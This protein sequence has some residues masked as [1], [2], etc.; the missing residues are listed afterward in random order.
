MRKN[1]F[2]TAILAIIIVFALCACG[3]DGGNSGDYVNNDEIVDENSNGYDYENNG[4]DNENAERVLEG[5]VV[6]ILDDE[7]LFVAQLNLSEEMLDRT[8]E[9]WFESDEISDVYR[10]VAN[11][12]DIR[13]GTEIRISFAI[14]TMS[15]PPLVPDWDYEE[16]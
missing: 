11:G 9:E 10:L 15:I 1:K 3:D 12:S 6:A 16:L 5:T 4:Y 13:V 8:A 14:T 7:L 2:L